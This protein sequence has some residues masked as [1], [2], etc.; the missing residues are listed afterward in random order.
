MDMDISESYFEPQEPDPAPPAEKVEKR[1]APAE[2]AR[3]ALAVPAAQIHREQVEWLE[4]GRIPLRMVTVLA[5]IGGL[6]KSQ[7]ACL[8]AAANPAVTLIATAEDSPSTTVRPRLEAVQADLD[9]V[10]FVN[11]KTAEG[12]E[13]GISIPDDMEELD[14]I[15]AET[16]ARLVVV[17]P[18]VAHLP[19]HIDSH[20]DQSVRRALA[21]LYRLAEARN[22]AVLALLHLNKA[23]GLAPLMR[24]GGSGAFGNAARSVLLLDR[25]PDDPDGEE[26]NQRVL[27]HIK[28]NVAPLA[29]SLVYG[30]KPILLPATEDD[31]EVETSRL[32]LIGESPHNGR[33]LLASA[34][35]DERTALDEAE[36]FLLAELGDGERHDAGEI[37]KAAAKIGINYR[38]LR[39]ARK[40]VGAETE[41]E[42]FGSGGAWKWWLPKGTGLPGKP[43]L[44]LEGDSPGE[45]SPSADL[46]P[47]GTADVPLLGDEMYPVLL[48][49]AV[50]DGH[51]TQA[52]AERAYQ[53]HGLVEQASAT[54]SANRTEKPRDPS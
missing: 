13:D 14:R 51:I 24:L 52:E 10:R 45:V 40:V 41:K 28:C 53:L 48:A 16:E 36:E 23:T 17:D 25:D 3:R 8:Y 46:T 39:R 1:K 15:V 27:A 29:P 50:R 22:C 12:I 11:I 26:G 44:L 33:A 21:P 32:D 31:P 9:R 4:P 6:G 35:E 54:C 38:T 19:M 5:G 7:L 49:D 42:G 18:L 2:P 47:S 37:T 43:A 30:V 34:S 20:K